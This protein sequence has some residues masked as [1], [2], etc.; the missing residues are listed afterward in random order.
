MNG[1][2]TND[3]TDAAQG[4]ASSNSFL[5]RFSTVFTHPDRSESQRPDDM[6]AVL[7]FFQTLSEESETDTSPN[8]SPGNIHSSHEVVEVNGNERT[9]GKDSSAVGVV[10]KNGEST[11]TTTV[12]EHDS[13]NGTLGQMTVVPRNMDSEKE[14]NANSNCLVQPEDIISES[15]LGIYGE[16]TDQPDDCISERLSYLQG[17]SG[18]TDPVEQRVMINKHRNSVSSEDCSMKEPIDTQNTTDTANQDMTT[19]CPSTDKLEST[20]Q[21]SQCVSTNNRHQDRVTN[22]YDKDKVKEMK[23]TEVSTDNYNRLAWLTDSETNP[24]ARSYQEIFTYDNHSQDS[25]ADSK[26]LPAADVVATDLANP[27]AVMAGEPATSTPLPSNTR[28]LVITMT[29]T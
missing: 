29:R 2:N 23:H 28:K 4:K 6:M 5:D 24:R 26:D 17:Y 19:D 7:K 27:S 1:V 20:D 18:S 16:S 10:Q 9:E 3:N 14:E 11:T 8:T 15:H 13:M 21:H 12:M 22:N 25:P